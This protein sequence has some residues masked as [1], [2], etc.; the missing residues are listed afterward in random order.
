MKAPDHRLIAPRCGSRRGWRLVGSALAAASLILAAQAPA[1]GAESAVWTQKKINFIYQGFTSRYSCQGLEDA[2]RSV[3]LQLGAR[4]SDMNLR[5]TGCAAGPNVPSPYPGVSGTF[6][7]L[8]PAAAESNGESVQAEWRTVKVSV[9]WGARAQTGQCELIDQVKAKILP[10]FAARNVKFQ[11]V[12]T[13]NTVR[14]QG[15]TLQ[16]EVLKPVTG[17]HVANAE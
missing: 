14:V 9:S 16:A 13:P 8:E 17:A 4:Q 10:L 6:S 5:Q 15:S 1:F 12:C 7:V 11:S 2:V 3:L